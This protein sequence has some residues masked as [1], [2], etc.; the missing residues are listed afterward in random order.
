MRG[1]ETPWRCTCMPR[2]HGQGG[3]KYE[4]SGVFKTDG[5]GVSDD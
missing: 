1:E 2:K 5:K 4:R 3:G